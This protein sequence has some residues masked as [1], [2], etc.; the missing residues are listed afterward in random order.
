M[1]M[2]HDLPHRQ[3]QVLHFIVRNIYDKK[4]SPTAQEIADGTGLIIQQVQTIIR[5]LVVKKKITRE[6]YNHRSIKIVESNNEH[7]KQNF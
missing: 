2:M 5:A 6:R 7:F 1:V 4:E 3:R